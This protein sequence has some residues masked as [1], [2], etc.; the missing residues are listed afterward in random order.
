MTTES[1]T[2]PQVASTAV[3][4]RIAWEVALLAL[5][6]PLFLIYAPRD[7]ALYITLAL[8]FGG[9]IFIT[10]QHT[11]HLVWGPAPAPYARRLR[12]TLAWVGS[13]TALNFVAFVVWGI[14]HE[15]P[16]VPAHWL[17]ALA[18]YFGWA[19]LQQ[20]I[21]QFYL[22]GRLRV[23]LPWG[24]PWLPAVLSAAAY[25]AVHYPDTGLMLLTTG[26][27]CLWSLAYQR[28][29]LLW[30]IA[31]SHAVLGASYYYAVVGADLAANVM[32]RLLPLLRQA[33]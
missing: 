27:G 15:R 24:Q 23:L 32:T 2:A 3:R 26:V 18:L 5:C 11:R 16:L 13:F 17:L 1:S 33:W 8:L 25:G 7:S 30:P 9:Y 29:R 22:H 28:D 6:T 31:L 20:L 12:H 4:Q 21:F 14:W 10:R 19:M